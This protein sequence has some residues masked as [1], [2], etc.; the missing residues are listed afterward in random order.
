MPCVCGLYAAGGGVTVA[1]L[2]V[3]VI[4]WIMLLAATTVACVVFHFFTTLWL[5][6]VFFDV[7]IKD[8]PDYLPYGFELMRR[9]LGLVVFVLWLSVLLFVGKRIRFVQ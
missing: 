1:R 9:A 4:K 8:H 3:F 6:G 7:G 5:G 2:L